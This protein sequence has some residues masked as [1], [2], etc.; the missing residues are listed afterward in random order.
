MYKGQIEIQFYIGT[1]DHVIIVKKKHSLFQKLKR[2]FQVGTN[3]FYKKK[4]KILKENK[5]Q[6]IILN[7]L[8]GK[9]LF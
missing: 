9:V 7:K 4:C 2:Y 6:T 8:Y 5:T 3:R 1:S